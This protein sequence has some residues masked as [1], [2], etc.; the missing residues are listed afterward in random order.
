MS[1]HFVLARLLICAALGPLAWPAH[2]VPIKPASDDDVIEVLPAVPGGRS[3]QKRL[4]KALAAQ[5]RDVTLALTVA[6]RYLEQAHESGDPRFAGM[7]MAA[8]EPWPDEAT[9]S[10]DLLMM[11]A[12]VQ[13]YLHQFD[14]SVRLLER[15]LARPSGKG[16]SQAWLTSATSAPRAGRYADSDAACKQLA[17]TGAALHARACMA[18][19]AALRGDVDRARAAF[20]LLLSNP[21]EAAATQA[22]LSTS[23]AELEQRSGN[24]PAAE[25]AF[26]RA[27]SLAPDTYTRLAYA[28]LLIERRRPAE[29]LS[30]LAGEARSDTVLLRLVIA[31]TQARSATAA[32]DVAEMRERIA[33]ANQRPEAM[34][35]HGREQAMFALAVENDPDRALDL[36]RGNVAQQRGRSM[37]RAGAGGARERPRRR[38]AG[39]E[40]AATEMGLVD[41]A[42]RRCCEPPVQSL[43]ILRGPAAACWRS[44]PGP[45]A[46]GSDSY[47]QIDR[48]RPPASRAM[49]HRAARSDAAIDLDAART[50]S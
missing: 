14:D 43:G 37:S 45:R 34:V 1:L 39:S 31:G 50:A 20:A 25:A 27:L 49:G 42:S 9:M 8:I 17:P 47:L 29:V 21:R 35:F 4:R 23:L 13:Q 33:L 30:L 12:T 18:E 2:S 15:L 41:A 22:W 26:K 24:G 46:Q 28:D 16:Q 10:D 40:A 36:A 7:A 32:A 6:R 19:N 11:R 44:P 48:A 38:A 5:P 3:E